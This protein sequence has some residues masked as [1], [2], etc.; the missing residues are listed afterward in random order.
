MSDAPAVPAAA[1]TEGETMH[2]FTD[3][4]II[5]TLREV[6]EENP[7]YTYRA[8]ADLKDE[9]ENKPAVLAGKAVAP[10]CFYVHG[11]EPG[12]IVGHVMNRLGIPLDE[13]REWEG[14]GIGST[15]PNVGDLVSPN[16][17]WALTEAQQVQDAGDPWREALAA[18][19]EVWEV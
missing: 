19:E 17:E 14:K 6:V 7:D 10:D 4:Q 15:V 3:E 12:C 1:T 9:W 13:L 11:D 8:P 18:A 16:A 2:R 5:S